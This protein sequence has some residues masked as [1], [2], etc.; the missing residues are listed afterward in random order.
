M[1][2]KGN[3]RFEKLL[4]IDGSLEGLL[5]APIE[6]KYVYIHFLDYNLLLYEY[7]IGICYCW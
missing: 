4:R 5:E 1:K 7:L 3:I 2:L 6:V